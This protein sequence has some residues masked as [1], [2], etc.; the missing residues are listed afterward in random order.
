[1]PT[2]LIELTDYDLQQFHKR[3]GS[4][5]K[6]LRQEKGVTQLELSQAIGH[7]AVSLISVAEI[8]HNNRHFNLE[9][10]YKISLALECDMCEFFKPN[11][12]Q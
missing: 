12:D 2:N 5:V 1:M 9:Q 8:N 6:K 11:E 10:L 7:K 4:N 3:I